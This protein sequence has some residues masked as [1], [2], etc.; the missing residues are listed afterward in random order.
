MPEKQEPIQAWQQPSE[1]D[2]IVSSPTD[3]AQ[4]SIDEA[5]PSQKFGHL[6]GLRLWSLAIA[7]MLSVYLV[8]LDMTMLATVCVFPIIGPNCI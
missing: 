6:Q 2:R 4:I 5:D 3:V 1:E 8:G 7:M